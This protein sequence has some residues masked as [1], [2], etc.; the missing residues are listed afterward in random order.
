MHVTADMMLEV[1]TSVSELLPNNKR[2]E[3]ATR[4]VHIF[5]DKGLDGS[6][7]EMIKG[8]DDYLDTAIDALYTGESDH[9]EED[10]YGQLYLSDD[11]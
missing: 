6:D 7:F 3:L 5:A 11:E 1:W 9:M 2:E 8:E 4:L 10:D